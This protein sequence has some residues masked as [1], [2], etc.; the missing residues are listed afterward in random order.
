MRL[1]LSVCES[2][3]TEAPSVT[4]ARDPAGPPLR[5]RPCGRNYSGSMTVRT[6]RPP[7]ACLSK[8]SASWRP[9]PRSMTSTPP[10]RPSLSSTGSRG[11]RRS[12][13]TERMSIRPSA[14]LGITPR[15]A[16]C[17]GRPAAFADYPSA[18]GSTR[19]CAQRCLVRATPRQA[20]R[21]LIRIG[22]ADP[23]PSPAR[24]QPLRLA[25]APGIARGL[26]ISRRA[27]L[28]AA[29]RRAPSGGIGCHQPDASQGQRH[30]G[31]LDRRWSVADRDGHRHADDWHQE[32]G[33][34]QPDQ[35]Q[36]A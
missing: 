7:V 27:R 35:R 15:A 20:D 13:S 6:T 14:I 18:P 22:P 25:H 5:A 33:G 1:R 10:I 2:C 9:A 28:F 34:A 8:R 11:R 26:R 21:D 24:P 16:A 3:Q 19:L 23:S 29:G 12:A 17:I 4:I 36:P 32:Q 30:A 31:Q